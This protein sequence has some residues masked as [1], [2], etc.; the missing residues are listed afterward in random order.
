MLLA[1][2]TGQIAANLH[3]DSPRQDIPALRE[4]RMHI[5][6]DHEKIDYSYTAVNNLSVTGV[7]AHI[8]L[9]GHY[10]PKVW[11]NMSGRGKSIFVLFIQ[12][13]IF[14]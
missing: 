3:C 7:N 6:T 13:K 9:K 11:N 8:L 1:Y 2:H 5:V 4:G 10:K 14:F 12:R